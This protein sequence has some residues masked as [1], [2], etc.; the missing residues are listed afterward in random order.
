MDEL[1]NKLIKFREITLDI[2]DSLEKE[3]YD[4]P[5]R[6]LAERENIIKEI[7]NLNWKKEEFKKINEELELLL[8][9]K[10]LQSL[11]IEKK[12]VIKLKLRKTSE[13]KEA[14]KNY[15]TKQFNTQSI[16]NTKI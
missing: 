10:K 13:N 14:N 7:N 8:I 1:R 9:E 4:S 6:L 5:E 2:I 16:L 3:D 15:S 12:G 11:M